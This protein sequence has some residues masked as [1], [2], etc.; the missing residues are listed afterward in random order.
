ME[1]EQLFKIAEKFKKNK[2]LSFLPRQTIS[3]NTYEDTYYVSLICNDNFQVQ[4][5]LL[6]ENNNLIETL[7]NL[8]DDKGYIAKIA[9]KF[10]LFT[11]DFALVYDINNIKIK[12][13]KIYIGSLDI[14]GV[15]SNNNYIYVYSVSKDKIIQF[16]SD[17]NCI[18]EHTNS[19]SKENIRVPLSLACNEETFFSIPLMLPTE[20]Q[21]IIMK[22]F[23][24]YYTGPEIAKQ[25][26]MIH[27]CS[28]NENENTLYISM[29]NIVW[30]IKNGTEFSYLYFKD[31]A[32]TNIYYDN[33]IGKLIINFG[34]AKGK[35]IAG[36]IIRLTDQDIYNKATTITD[37]TS[38]LQYSEPIKYLISDEC[39]H[40]N[41]KKNKNL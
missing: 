7:L 8:D 25:N 29:Y 28:F 35:H 40:S 9:N 39:H 16:D 22:K 21:Y 5:V 20:H 6:D 32:I 2:N 10:Y 37:N 4:L 18:E 19:Y 30:I 31:E 1:L 15:C 11:E 26:D 3:I 41:T 38:M 36:A 14:Q 27:S 12:P 13:S 23:M 24:E 34:K 17:L 33:D